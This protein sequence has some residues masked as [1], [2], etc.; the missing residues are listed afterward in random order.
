MKKFK[1]LKTLVE[2]EIASAVVYS[3]LRLVSDHS[4]ISQSSFV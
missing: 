2:I 1:E 4:W 3:I